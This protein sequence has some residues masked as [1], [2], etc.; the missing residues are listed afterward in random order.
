MAVALCDALDELSDTLRTT[1]VLVGVDG[2]SHAEAAQVL[3]CPEGTVAWRV[4]EARKKLRVYLEQKG[5]ST[6]PEAAS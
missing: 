2:L 3:G 1:L 6:D 5:F 4:H